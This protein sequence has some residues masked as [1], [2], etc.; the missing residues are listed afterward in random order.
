VVPAASRRP[1]RRRT[2]QRR[3]R[4]IA[5][6]VGVVALCVGVVSA[7]LLTLYV[8]NRA[9][10]AKDALESAQGR[11]TAFRSALGQP[12]APSTTELAAALRRDTAKAAQQVDD[13][14]WSAFERIPVL[15]SNLTAFR[16]TADLVDA[17]V[18]D[19]ITPV[20]T[21][22]DGLSVD[23]L[24]P[25]DGR[26]DI[27][28]LQD[29]TPAVAELDDAITAADA[30][31]RAIDTSEVVPQLQAPIEQVRSMLGEAAPV[32]HELRKVMP[33]LYPALGGEGTRHYLL[34]FQNNAE[35]RA[36]G[37]NPASMVML[38]VQDGKVSLSTQA[39][40][41]DFNRFKY[42]PLQWDG[43]WG[44]IY[45]PHTAGY[46]SNI[47]MT[48]D[49]PEVAQM[50]RAMW[51]KKIGGK[52]D[53]VLSFDPVALS[54]LLRATGPIT[55]A[56]G[57][58]LT[59]D[60]AVQ[61]LLSDVYARYTD[62]TVQDAVFASAAQ[63]VFAAV[64]NGQ[65]SMTG[66]IEQLQPMLDEQRLKAWSVREDEQALLQGSPAGNMLPDDDAEATTFGVYNNDDATSKMSY[67]MDST[68][69]VTARSCRTPQY[70]VSTTVT[71]TLQPS[72][73]AGLT[74]YVL[75]NQDRVAPGADRQRV[76]L[77]GPV[78]ARLK[79]VWIGGK[80]VT[81]GTNEN[82]RLNTVPDATGMDDHRPAVDGVL[83]G[84]PVAS[85]SITAG[86]GEHV[87][88]KAVFTG[89]TGDSGELAVSHTPKVRE[90]PVTIAR[91]ACG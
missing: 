82:W 75:A 9:L 65:G 36:S 16:Q 20:A 57:E 12:G 27:A 61:Y 34:L 77:Y 70:T 18:R 6:T 91:E 32:T 47:T 76:V 39:S 54:Y 38:V 66:Y 30:S 33:V 29:L 13:P 7:V 31:A 87:T 55:L 43:D 15:G 21:A 72:Q 17:L 4:R 60:N 88:V 59:S 22:A 41:A 5:T 81:F 42:V 58:Q 50:A 86:A 52:V 49:F 45:G 79:H 35:E 64:T 28:P 85:V 46:L 68:I 14:V 8:G 2:P 89:G 3:A 74:Q 24:K 48:P 90:V 23:S 56:T 1:P 53:G 11:L 63:S 80:K 69:D 83:K 44:R 37:G 78:G 51:Q 71:N 25:V 62:P 10:V 84:R 40:T 19:G 73:V 26:L 67:Y